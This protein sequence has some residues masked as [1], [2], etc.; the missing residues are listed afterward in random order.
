MKTKDQM[1]FHEMQAYW[2]T[3]AATNGHALTRSL[4]HGTIEGTSFTDAEKV[5]DAMKIAQNHMRL[6]RELAEE[7]TEELTEEGHSYD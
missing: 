1:K 4:F 7:L 6:Y 2:W 3:N 5:S